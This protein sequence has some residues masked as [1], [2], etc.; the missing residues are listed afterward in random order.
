MD[1]CL[2]SNIS[3]VVETISRMCELKTFLESVLKEERVPPPRPCYRQKNRTRR[4]SLFHS[5][6]FTVNTL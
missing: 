5:K 3:S 1:D 6:H 2:C 4:R